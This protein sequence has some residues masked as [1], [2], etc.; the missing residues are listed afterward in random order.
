VELPI[1]K[2]GCLGL[3]LQRNT[4]LIKNGAVAALLCRGGGVPSQ[5]CNPRPQP[6]V[7]PRRGRHLGSRIL[8]ENEDRTTACA[9]N[10][11]ALSISDRAREMTASRLFSP[12]REQ[13]PSCRYYMTTD[14]PYAV[15]SFSAFA[16][17]RFFMR[18]PISFIGVRSGV[19]PFE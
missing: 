8:I 19:R 15:F 7:R 11:R 18:F 16:N 6:T 13:F 17:N 9:A 5:V 14:I 2:D 10:S 12:G 1:P 3:L 4:K